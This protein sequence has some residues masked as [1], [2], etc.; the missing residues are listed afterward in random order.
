MLL[1]KAE[2]KAAALT[3]SSSRPT[4]L[5]R[6]EP[7]LTLL[8]DS[9][10]GSRVKDGDPAG[11]AYWLTTTATRSVPI[12]SWCLSTI[13]HLVGGYYRLHQPLDPVRCRFDYYLWALVV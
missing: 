13:I 7:H 12:R 2:S 6:G 8:L 10:S 1:Q 4:F 11:P 9:G 3:V 5:N